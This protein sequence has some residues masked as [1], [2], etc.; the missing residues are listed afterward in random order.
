MN[1]FN[2][3]FRLSLYGLAAL[4]AALSSGCDRKPD[5]SY[6][7]YVEGQ[8]VY[9]ASPQSGRLEH[10]GV[11][12]GDSV[13]VNHPLFA[14]DQEPEAS[15]AMQARQLL[16]A[17]EARLAD[18]QTG[19]RP[20]EVEIMR[21]QLAQVMAEQKKSVEILKSYQSQYASGGVALTDLITARAAVETNDAL[22]RQQRSNQAVAALPGRDEQ[23]KAQAAVVEA[24]RAAFQQATWK[25]QQKTIVAPRAGLVFDT[26]YREG[27]WVAAGS[28]IVQMLPPENLEIRFFVPETVVGQIKPG[29]PI[30]VHCDGCAAEIPA[31]ITFISPQVEYTPPVIYSNETRAK[32]VFMIIAKPPADQASRLHPG[33]PLQAWLQ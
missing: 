33:Q 25:L 12:R 24:D 29:Q 10:L 9:V 31:S 11:T 7:G 17:D 3:R 27:E 20:P 19:K 1:A 13:A 18:L 5:T 4:L 8:F 30:K 15:A 26:L 2:L 16:H 28:P 21:A 14:L 22:A 23:I 6:Q 32:L